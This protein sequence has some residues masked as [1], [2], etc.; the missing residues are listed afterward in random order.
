MKLF[1]YISVADAVY[2]WCIFI[3][4]YICIFDLPDLMNYTLLY[5]PNNLIH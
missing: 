3:A 1:M 5:G 2:Y 4:N